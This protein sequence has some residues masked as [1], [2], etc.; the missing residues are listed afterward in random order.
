MKFKVGDK[1]VCI[2]DNFDKTRPNFEKIF[3]NLPIKNVVYTIREYEEPAIKLVEIVNPV[4]IINIDGVL[5]EDEGAFH[6]KRFAP[7]ISSG[8][9]LAES[10]SEIVKKNISKKLVVK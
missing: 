1:V 7:L 5:I 6:E 10:I 8:L 3:P 2:D 9:N 4:T